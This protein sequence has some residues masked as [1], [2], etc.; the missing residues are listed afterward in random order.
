MAQ[1]GLPEDGLPSYGSFDYT[2]VPNFRGLPPRYQSTQGAGQH[3]LYL[4]P[5]YTSSSPTAVPSV[6][7]S[8]SYH[9]PSWKSKSGER[10]KWLGNKCL[11]G[12]LIGFPSPLELPFRAAHS[13]PLSKPISRQ[14]AESR[15]QP[16]ATFTSSSD[17]RYPPTN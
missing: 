7:F 2:V 17:T 4:P 14:P 9:T 1:D 5:A 16:V 8:T 10:K 12:F 3:P 13:F 11:L 15:F 6:R